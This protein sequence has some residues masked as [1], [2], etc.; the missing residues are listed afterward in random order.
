MHTTASPSRIK[1]QP[2]SIKEL[3]SARLQ[4]RLDIICTKFIEISDSIPIHIFSRKQIKLI[5]EEL[6]PASWQSKIEAIKVSSLVDPDILLHII[7]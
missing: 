5:I 6:H 4:I 3:P 7:A 2:L 1:K